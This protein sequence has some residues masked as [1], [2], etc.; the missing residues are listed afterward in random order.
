MSYDEEIETFFRNLKLSE[1]VDNYLNYNKTPHYYRKTKVG[2]MN[3]IKQEY[4]IIDENSN[5]LNIPNYMRDYKEMKKYI[6]NTLEKCDD[7]IKVMTLSEPEVETC[8]V[9]MTE[10]EETNYV[11]PKCKHKVCAVCFTNN[12]K[13]NKHSGDCCVL[14]REPIC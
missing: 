12:I 9:C 8:P 10:F 2:T 5:N 14:C 7:V 6:N 13:Y 4:P 1:E 3:R 11:I